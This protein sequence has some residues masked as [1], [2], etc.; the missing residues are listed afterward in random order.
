[1]SSGK[2]AKSAKQPAV[3]AVATLNRPLTR[4]E[5]SAIV[6]GVSAQQQTRA[7][8]TEGRPA[9]R[10]GAGVARVWNL[11]ADTGWLSD[12]GRRTKHT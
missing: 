5:E 4:A 7:Q 3:A 9:G 2:V 1:M 8:G 12:T 10:D 11:Q 6:A